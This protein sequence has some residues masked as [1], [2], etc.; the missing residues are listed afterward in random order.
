MTAVEMI[1]R[2]IDES[3][4]ALPRTDLKC[5]VVATD[6]SDAAIAAFNAA[7]L[8]SNRNSAPV[9]VL[10]VLEPMPPLFPTPEGF[11]LSPDFD[12]SRKAAQTALVKDQI[13]AFD[14]CDDWAIELRMG[15]PADTIVEFAHEQN[16]GL[17]IV[18]MNKHG[19]W[20]RILG[21]ETALE[22]SRLTDIPLLVASPDMK[23]L[24]HRIVVA[25]DLNPDSL[26]LVPD[27]V[28]QIADTPSISCVHVK[29]RAEFLG[30]DWADIDS[31]YELALKERF[32]EVE[33]A[34]IRAGLRPDLVIL[35]GDVTRE[36]ADF[37]KY[38]KTEL[39]VVGVRRRR[40]KSRAI[41]G[42]MAGKVLRSAECSVL[43]SPNIIANEIEGLATG[44]DTETIRDPRSWSAALGRFTARNA[45]RIVNLEVDD[46]EIGA[47]ME[48]TSYPFLGADYDHKDDRLTITLGNMHNLD[49]HLSRTI[50]KP[51]SIAILSVNDRDSALAVRHSG[52]QTLLTF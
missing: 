33:K 47:L 5:I 12:D 19:V 24:P 7:R 21:E 25:L 8:I 16:A 45:G 4:F 20:G 29:P 26:Q 18:G 6:G 37:V 34:L 50:V 38:S 27:A 49:R 14:I 40:G 46:P 48:A 32:F 2:E 28:K 13:K 44:G 43:I 15:R 11:L 9:Q 41:G 39:V 51:E 22:I 42:R 23:R 35:H 31:G 30:V 36:L 3:T 17:I 10:T 1:T 52:G